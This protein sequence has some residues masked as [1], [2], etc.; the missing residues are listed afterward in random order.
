LEKVCIDTDVLIELSKRTLLKYIKPHMNLY[1][2][3]IS[4]YEYLRGLAVLGRDVVYAERIL[5][6]LFTIIPLTEKTIIKAAEIYAS[7]YRRGV[8]IPDPDILIA[9]SC[10][11]EEI[12]LSTF[13]IRHFKR[14]EE[15][16]LEIV[17]PNEIINAI[18]KSR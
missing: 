9:A 12:P 15:Y 8:L 6:T 11:I 3:I 10:I 16:G 2:S 5:K 18:V 4:V 17:N 13:N 7:L 1:L 14:L